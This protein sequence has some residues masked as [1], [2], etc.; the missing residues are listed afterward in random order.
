MPSNY[1]VH[2]AM[3]VNKNLDVKNMHEP[4]D[5]WTDGT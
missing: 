5:I 1:P 3:E 4:D 2:M